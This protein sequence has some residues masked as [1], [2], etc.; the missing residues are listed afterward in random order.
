MQ[1]ATVH[2]VRKEAGEETGKHAKLV[3][4]FQCGGTHYVN[5]CKFKYTICHACSK[6]GHLAKK[7]RCSMGKGKPGQGKAQQAQAA[8]HHLEE[9]KEE[10][11]CAYNMF[12]VEADEEPPEPYYAT[13]TVR[14]QNIKSEIDLG[15]T[16]S[17]ISEETYRR[18]WGSD[19]SPIRP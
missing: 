14:L 7:C 15:A 10:A 4:C 2:Q 9:D 12:G 3:E 16:A 5:V 6:K 1:T 8:T 17:V 18:T 19:L 11:T 13:A